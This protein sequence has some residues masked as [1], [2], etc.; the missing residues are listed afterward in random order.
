VPSVSPLLEL[1]GRRQSEEE[2]QP[3]S[4]RSEPRTERRLNFSSTFDDAVPNSG[5]V[6]GPA[7]ARAPPAA[8]PPGVV[9]H[10]PAP[11]APDGRVVEAARYALHGDDTPQGR[12]DSLGVAGVEEVCPRPRGP[13]VV[14]SLC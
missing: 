6:E 3:V 4:L 7:V 13:S 12:D 14:E 10:T 11:E 2:S 9:G 8:P 5:G 1:E